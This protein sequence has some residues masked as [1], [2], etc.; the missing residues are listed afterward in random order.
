[1]LLLHMPLLLH[2]EGG[3]L[4]HSVEVQSRLGA[5]AHVEGLLCRLGEVLRLRRHLGSLLSGV[6]LVQLR[7]VQLHR[8][9]KGLRLS[10]LLARV[11]STRGCGRWRF[12]RRRPCRRWLFLAGA[13][14]RA[15]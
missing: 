6:V 1:M 13:R 8:L 11:L 3:L 5:V 15:C 14:L 12:A 7:L 10:W 4:D 9:C 2:E